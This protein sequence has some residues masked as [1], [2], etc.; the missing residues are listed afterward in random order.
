MNEDGLRSYSSRNASL[1]FVAAGLYLPAW[2]DY[3]DTYGDRPDA[4]ADS[5]TGM[6]NGSANGL[7]DA[8]GGE[9]DFNEWLSD[10]KYYRT[11]FERDY[12]DVKASQN[13]YENYASPDDAARML[14]EMAENGDDGLM[15]YDIASEGVV[16]P[17]GATVHAHRGQGIKDS[18]N[19]FMVISNGKKK[20]SVAVMTQN[21]GRAVAD[22]LASRMLDKV[23]N[24][25]LRN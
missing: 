22:Q 5:L 19:Y 17:S 13:G 18:Y 1:S 8:V 3:R 2:L 21:Q 25:M 6:N 23:W 4:Y 14:N 20:V 16:I 7:I 10:N 9:S 15:N 11:R 12:G 24:T